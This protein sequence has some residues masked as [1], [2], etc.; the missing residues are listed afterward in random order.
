MTALGNGVDDNGIWTTPRSLMT[1][2]GFK[3]AWRR[4]MAKHIAAGSERFRGNA[5]RAKAA[6]DA[7]DLHA[8]QKAPCARE[9]GDDAAPLP[10]RRGE[11]RAADVSGVLDSWGFIRQRPGKRCVS[12]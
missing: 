5:V 6:S 1:D 10:P 9:R 11:D 8:A 12:L 3:S 2:S 4:A 7:D